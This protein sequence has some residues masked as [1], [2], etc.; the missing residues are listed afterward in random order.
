MLEEFNSAAGKHNGGYRTQGLALCAA[1]Y[2]HP[3]RNKPAITSQ[4]CNLQQQLTDDGET[5]VKSIINVHTVIVIIG[6]W[7]AAVHGVPCRSLSSGIGSSRRHT[8]WSW[9][10]C[11]ADMT[12]LSAT[13]RGTTVSYR[14]LPTAVERR[15]SQR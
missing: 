3:Y 13:K 5:D 8:S 12:R 4:C 14:G 9:S 6:E 11:W 2:H 7:Q 15:D 1:I 10:V